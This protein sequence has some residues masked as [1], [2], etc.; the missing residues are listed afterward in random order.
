MMVVAVA[1]GGLY[2]GIGQKKKYQN[3]ITFTE[4]WW[5]TTC[6]SLGLTF[7]GLHAFKPTVIYVFVCITSTILVPITARSATTSSAGF[8][9]RAALWTCNLTTD[10]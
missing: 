3:A 8:R 6:I 5:I 10:H 1:G 4:S 2:E 7:A 9:E